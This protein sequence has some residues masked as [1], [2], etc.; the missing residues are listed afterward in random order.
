MSH[1]DPVSKPLLLAVTMGDPAGVGPELCLDALADQQGH[2]DYL[3][4]VF[5]DV[6][7]LEA[8]ASA[9]GRAAGNNW[10]TLDANAEDFPENL[11]CLSRPAVAHCDGFDLSSL[12]PGIVHA[13]TGRASL[14]YIQRAVQRA[15]LGQ[16]AAV[17]TAPIHKEAIHAAGSPYPGHTEMLAALTGAK[18]CCM[19]LAAEEM[20][21]SLVT[22]HIGLRAV[23]DALKESR[24]LEVI[25]LT[26]RAAPALVTSPAR[27]EIAVLGLNPHA[28]E[29]GLFG[30]REEERIIRPAIEAARAAG[31]HAVGPLPPDTAF[32]PERRAITAAYVCM[33]HD[34]G[35]IPLK[36]LAFDTAVN[37]TLGLPIVRTSVDHGTA[38]D[39][40]WQGKAR[41]S[42]LL[43]AL[44]LAA[45]LARQRL[46]THLTSAATGRC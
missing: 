4:V 31:I 11:A 6:R 37:I 26:A 35:L 39:I 29:G 22:T 32:L 40:A 12:R 42:S 15:N 28:G 17:V 9:T 38:L 3:P 23:P 43:A 41:S 7:V 25:Q 30:S 33:Y 13:E 8:A 2:A 45:R 46:T 36:M 16:V 19:M 21:C 27:R 5:G 20:A 10:E 14:D 34:Q 24:I 1:L 44:R 18:R